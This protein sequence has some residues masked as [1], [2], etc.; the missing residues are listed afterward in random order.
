MGTYGW[1][2]GNI[3]REQAESVLQEAA[4][5]HKAGDNIFL[6]RKSNSSPKDF[7]L[8]WMKVEEVVGNMMIKVMGGGSN[9]TFVLDVTCPGKKTRYFSNLP[10]LLAHF[11]DPECGLPNGHLHSFVPTANPQPLPEP[12]EIPLPP[13][14]EGEGP[15]M[16]PIED[17][18]KKPRKE[19]PREA[20]SDDEDDAPPP[21]PSRPPSKDELQSTQQSGDAKKVK[22]G[23]SCSLM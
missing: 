22:R 19:Q 11:Q 5:L 14:E 3:S 4:P 20:Y 10:D 7:V 6:I 12:E 21:L 9:K 18:Q 15:P 13:P 2:H 16:G 8:T 1:Y 23:S 17:F